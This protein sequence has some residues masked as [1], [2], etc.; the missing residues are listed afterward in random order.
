VIEYI[1]DFDD[2]QALMSAFILDDV[3]IEAHTRIKTLVHEEEN[4]EDD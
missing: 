2:L 3:R 1:F 4:Q